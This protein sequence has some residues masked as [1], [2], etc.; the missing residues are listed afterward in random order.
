MLVHANES[1]TVSNNELHVGKHFWNASTEKKKTELTETIQVPSIHIEELFKENEFTF[2]SVDIEGGEL[3]LLEQFKIPQCV[4]KLMIELHPK[5][6]GLEGTQKVRD[7][8]DAQGF[9]MIDQSG[10][11]V[12]YIR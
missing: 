6:I 2:M 9:K 3:L 11:S 1:S 7:L 12:L 5:V 4:S 8:I 10:N